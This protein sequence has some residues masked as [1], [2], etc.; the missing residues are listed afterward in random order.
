MVSPI[1]FVGAN[2]AKPGIGATIS[3]LPNTGIVK[4]F[5]VDTHSNI[6]NSF[7]QDSD[8]MIGTLT[9]P[10]TP[11]DN[12]TFH[13]YL[14]LRN[15]SQYRNKP[16]VMLGR[17]GVGA[18]QTIDRIGTLI[19]PPTINQTQALISEFNTN[20]P[21]EDDA[22]FINGDSGSPSFVVQDGIAALVGIHSV[23]S[24]SSNPILNFDSFVPHY[25]SELNV[26]MEQDGYRMT[27]AIPGSTTLTLN[28][29]LQA[30]II[31]AGH[32]FTIDLTLN[33]TGT[34]L[35]ENLRLTNTF[36]NGA[37]VSNTSGSEWFDQSSS[38]ETIARKAKVA[39]FSNTVYSITASVPSAGTA[40]HNVT[41][42]CDQFASSTQTFSIDVI[43]SFLSFTQGL[44]DASVAGDDDLDG[45][46]N[47]LEYVFGGNPNIASQFFTG[48]NSLLLPE[49]KQVGGIFQIS[50]IRRKDYIQRAISYDLESSNTMASETWGDATAQITKTTIDSIDVEFEKVTHELTS[51][52]GD[53][54]YRIK[55]TVSE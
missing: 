49:F 6:P 7:A 51:I 9:S 35:A 48:T 21:D 14:N 29:Q 32:P 28:H 25:I 41:F 15:N 3:F 10:I 34:T 44:A 53:Q 2:H 23:V 45:I 31:R 50:Y 22:Y 26:I 24:T 12:I 13:P 1:H 16:M 8:L 5:K 47:L 38:S 55:A 30:D 11:G 52:S 54:F 43:G 42:S 19:A 33:N 18:R 4:T 20:S 27:K 17:D 36:S 37:V 46:G 40:Q 39:S